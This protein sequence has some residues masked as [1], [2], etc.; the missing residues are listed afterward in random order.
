MLTEKID[1][2]FE[3]DERLFV[4]LASDNQN[5]APYGMDSAN[6]EATVPSNNTDP[7]SELVMIFFNW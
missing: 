3:S 5:Y 2:R 7:D 1:N 4:K 6:R